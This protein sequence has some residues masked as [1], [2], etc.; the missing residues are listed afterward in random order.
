MAEGIVLV[1]ACC[2][3]REE[4]TWPEPQLAVELASWALEAG[5]TPLWGEHK[6]GRYVRLF[7]SERCANANITKRGTLRVHVKTLGGACTASEN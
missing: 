1:C 2:G 3:R 6:F 4:T 7:C 5:W